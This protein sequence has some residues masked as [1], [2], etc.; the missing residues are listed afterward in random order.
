MNEK[1][2]NRLELLENKEKL[3]NKERREL[4]ALQKKVARVSQKESRGSFLEGISDYEILFIN[5]SDIEYQEYQD[6]TGFDKKHIEDLAKSIK[7]QG[8]LQPVVVKDLGNNKFLKIAGRHRIEAYKYL[9]RDKIKAILL[10]ENIS[11]EEI[12]LKTFHENTKRADYSIY[13]KVRFHIEYISTLFSI[14]EIDVRK[15]LNQIKNKKDS[16]DNNELDKIV[17]AV[18]ELGVFTVTSLL[19]NL[20][21]LD[22]DKAL[23][24]E[25]NKKSITYNV[26]LKIHRFFNKS[27]KTVNEKELIIKYIVENELS[28]TQTKNYLD[29]LIE[30]DQVEMT[31][32]KT[33]KKLN[34]R[35][36]T[37]NSE[38]LVKVLEFIESFNS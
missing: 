24:N 7:M 20:Y 9:G 13:D 27:I 4:T 19:N 32:T 8:L 16:D 28:N 29:S 21:I 30:K 1:E 5:I 37:L 34:K 25:L 35:I 31:R 15:K 14:N 36:N 26:A 22:M 3:S 23:V 12:L 2:L 33:I 10:P 6:R 38:D 18:D 11:N 17:K